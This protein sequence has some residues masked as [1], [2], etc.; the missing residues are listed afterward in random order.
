MNNKLIDTLVEELKLSRDRVDEIFARIT[1]GFEH[2][3][4]DVGDSGVATDHTVCFESK[5]NKLND[6]LYE[7]SPLSR[8]ECKPLATRIKALY[9]GGM[10]E[11]DAQ[12][13]VAKIIAWVAIETGFN[14][15]SDEINEFLSMLSELVDNSHP[16]PKIDEE[17]IEKAAKEFAIFGESI[18]HTRQMGFEKGAKWALSKVAK[19]ISEETYTKKQVEKLMINAWHKGSSVCDYRRKH[20]GGDGWKTA[21]EYTEAVLKEL[22]NE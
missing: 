3:P 12:K 18:D 8:K 20:G 22:N 1:P 11:A 6:I 5:T 16:I 17:E 9:S 4:A 13:L 15:H 7:N 21:S 14:I 10:D 19:P 2:L